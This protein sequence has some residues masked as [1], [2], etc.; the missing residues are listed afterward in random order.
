MLYQI[1]EDNV[2]VIVCVEIFD[3]PSGG[4]DC[5][6]TVFLT[7]IDGGKA[8]ELTLQVHDMI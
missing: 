7:S 5:D 2:S 8:G 3:V 1:S 6:I 4:A